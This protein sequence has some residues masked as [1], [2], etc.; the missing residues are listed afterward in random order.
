VIPSRLYSIIDVEVCARS[1][2][3]P[4]DLA[5]AHLNG[6]VRLL[7]LRAKAL[8]SG[9][10]LDLASAIAEDARSAGAT[11]I[12]NDR[13]DLAVLSGAAGVH[14]GQD[15]LS[16]AD[17]RRITGDAM[18]VGLSTHTHQQIAGATAAPISYLAIGPVF[19]TATKATG[20]DPVGEAGVRFAAAQAAVAGLPVAAIGGITLANAA[21]V[22]AAGAAAVAVITDIAGPDAEVRVRQYLSVLA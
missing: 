17:V 10:F 14:V 4:R 19:S 21:Q 18:I 16:P 2:W 13:A 12:V 20:Y 15:D 1:G 7:Q 22:I 8:D 11:F 6:G 5:R 3:T 9:P